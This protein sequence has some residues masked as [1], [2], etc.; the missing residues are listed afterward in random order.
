[1]DAREK[2]GQ[3]MAEVTDEYML[4]MRDKS[5]AYTLLMLRQGPRYGQPGSDQIIWEHGRRN[6]ELRLDGVLAVV[7]P[8]PDE[9]QWCGIGIFD[10][11][12]EDVVRIMDGDPGVQAGVFE[13]EVHAVRGFPGDMLPQ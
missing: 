9:S 3:A 5:K 4:E 12:P 2:G 13:Y 11:T 10:T 1:V 6:H 8:I 7:C